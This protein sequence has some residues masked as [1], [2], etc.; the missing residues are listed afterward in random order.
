MQPGSQAPAAPLIAADN[1]TMANPVRTQIM[2]AIRKKLFQN[3]IEIHTCGSPPNQ[4]T[5][6]FRMPICSWPSP[7][8][9]S[10]TSAKPATS[11]ASTRPRDTR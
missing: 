2:M 3:G 9:G 10:L 5:M 8:P 11:C 1:T 6:A 7:R 4:V